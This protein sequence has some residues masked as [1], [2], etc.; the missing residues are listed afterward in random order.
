MHHIKEKLFNYFNLIRFFNPTGSLLLSY[1]LIISFLLLERDFSNIKTLILFIIGAFLMRSA[2]C[3]IND[4][5]DYKFDRQVWRTKNRPIASGKV[6]KFSAIILLVIILLLA[7]LIL[8]EFNRATIILG[9]SFIIPVIIYP[10]TKRFFPYPQL[11]LGITFNLGVFLLTLALYYEINILTII[12]YISFLSWTIAYDTIY[13]HQDIEDDQALGLYS[14]AITF[15]KYNALIIILLYAIFMLGMLSAGILQGYH[16]LSYFI[17]LNIIA[18]Y[19]FARLSI[20]DLKNHI[21]C[22]NFFKFNNII[23]ILLIIINIIFAFL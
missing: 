20:L 17:S 7:L 5:C 6:S 11:F 3:I 18:L 4:L 23:G 21:E 9:L 19:I 12:L 14:S 22:A 16:A 15:G 2:G 10:L 1:P 8:I 13:A